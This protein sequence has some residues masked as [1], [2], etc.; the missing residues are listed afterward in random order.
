MRGHAAPSELCFAA[1]VQR[2]AMAS[3]G[4]RCSERP[5]AMRSARKAAAR[6]PSNDRHGHG[7]HR[8]PCRRSIFAA[9]LALGFS[10]NAPIAGGAARAG[11]RRAA[12]SR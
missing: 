7:D 5:M 6:P 1:N 12:A 4:P 2:Q 9:R 3:R 11:G 8:S 10:P